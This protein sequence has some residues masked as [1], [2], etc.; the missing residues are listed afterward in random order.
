MIF[1][2]KPGRS[3]FRSSRRHSFSKTYSS[4]SNKPRSRGNSSS[5][6]LKYIKLAKEAS[7]AGD[8]VQAEYYHQFAE[9]YS[10]H[11]V[12]EGI[13]P[14]QNKNIIEDPDKKNTKNPSL[15]NNQEIN[16]EINEVSNDDNIKS[17]EKTNIENEIDENEN[18]LDAVSFISKPAKKIS[19]LKK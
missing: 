1:T 14:L 3:G 2:K 15:E 7:A 16:Q 9:H 4:F 11:M 6:Y 13:K 19:K 12:D 18:S 8:S 17:L 5:L 10:R